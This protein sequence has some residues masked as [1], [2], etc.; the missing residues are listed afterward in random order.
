[1]SEPIVVCMPLRSRMT[2][3]TAQAL[4]DNMDG[5]TVT[6]L[7]EVGRPVRDARNA[8]VRRVA[9]RGMPG[10]TPVFW[11]DDDAWWPAGTIAAVARRLA[12]VPVVFSLH[13]VRFP[14]SLPSGMRLDQ[15]EWCERI[16][17]RAGG[18]MIC[19]GPLRDEGKLVPVLAASTHF[20][21]HRARLLDE[22]DRPFREAGY[23]KNAEPFTTHPA[24]VQKLAGAFEGVVDE[25]TEDA[26]FCL[27]MLNAGVAM[28]VDTTVR[29][30]HVEA[31]SGAAFIPLRE[32]MR[33]RENSLVPLEGTVGPGQDRS[34]GLKAYD[35]RSRE[36]IQSFFF[37]T[38]ALFSLEASR[39][40]L[41]RPD[42]R[43]LN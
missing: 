41:S 29:V 27:N 20:Y 23:A 35:G 34:Y 32:A 3:E 14:W 33:V 43:R 42:L 25:L 2:S 31:A 40:G 1:V 22:W 16:E 38:S 36:E 7:T 4:R 30:A 28:S 21:A 6:L 37:R 39:Q 18:L 5:F 13:T 15:Q 19:R 9:E 26:S 12:D 24:V 11:I 17:L 8:L 10:D